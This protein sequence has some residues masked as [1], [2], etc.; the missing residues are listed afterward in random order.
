[1]SHFSDSSTQKF[2][3]L[4]DS[5]PASPLQAHYEYGVGTG[6]SS[7]F[8]PLLALLSKS[9]QVPYEVS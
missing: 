5:Y 7:T 4:A 6:R 2:V 3:A 1:M 9:S 8:F